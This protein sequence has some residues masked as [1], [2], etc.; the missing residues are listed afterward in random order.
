[1]GDAVG[2]VVG[3]AV[4]EAVGE[5]LVRPSHASHAHK[6]DATLTCADAP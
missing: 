3:E 5:L 6:H 2:E 1:M 4:G